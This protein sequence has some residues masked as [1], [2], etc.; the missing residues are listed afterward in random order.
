[1]RFKDGREVAGRAIVIIKRP[2][3]FR[4]EVLG[5]FN[6]VVAVIVY[7]GTNLSLLALHENRIYKDY[8]LPVEA[9][10]IPQYLTGLPASIAM[11][12]EAAVG[13]QEANHFQQALPHGQCVYTNLQDEYILINQEG[14]IKEITSSGI[15]N[16]VHPIKV[17][18]DSYKK[19]DGFNLPFEISISNKSADIFIKYEHVELNQHVSEDLFDMPG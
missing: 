16:S 2:D 10:T 12:R 19:V 9:Y 5:P 18:M 17:F 7:N 11:N 1:M 3:K 15:K 6:Q 13:S 4:F 8:L 14:N